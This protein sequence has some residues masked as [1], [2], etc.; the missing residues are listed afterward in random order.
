MIADKID[1]ARQQYM[2]LLQVKIG[3][4]I[5]Q[6]LNS[7]QRSCGSE[8]DATCLGLLLRRLTEKNISYSA[9]VVAAGLSFSQSRFFTV[10]LKGL[11]PT[12]IAS[13]VNSWKR[14]SCGT[15]GGSY[16][17][18]CPNKHKP[19][20]EDVTKEAQKLPTSP[21]LLL[22]QH[23]NGFAFPA[24]PININTHATDFPVR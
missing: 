16:G 1:Q 9:S 6:L 21:P 22:L 2:D 4:R 19:F 3:E 24:T 8:C 13:M 12:F 15:R 14:E 20:G 5:E 17:P 10:S 7:Q 18:S 11:S 23:T